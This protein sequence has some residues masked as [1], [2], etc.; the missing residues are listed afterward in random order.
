MNNILP[1]TGEGNVTTKGNI[2]TALQPNALPNVNV[3]T[4]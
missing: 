3:K 4:K 1:K 2:I